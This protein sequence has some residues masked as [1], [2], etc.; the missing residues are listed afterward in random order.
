LTIAIFKGR[1]MAGHEKQAT[2]AAR[3][4]KHRAN[5][6]LKSEIAELE[7]QLD[8]TPGNRKFK[9]PVYKRLVTLWNQLQPEA[10]AS[11]EKFGANVISSAD[12]TISQDWC[13]GSTDDGEEHVLAEAHGRSSGVISGT[14]RNSQK[15][16][17]PNWLLDAKLVA[18]FQQ[19]LKAEKSAKRGTDDEYAAD[20][21]NQDLRLLRSYFVEGFSLEEIYL[22]NAQLPEKCDPASEKGSKAL[23]R[24]IKKL[25][26]SGY[27]LL[28][29]ST[30]TESEKEAARLDRED[31]EQRII[32]RSQYGK[33]ADPDRFL[34]KGNSTRSQESE[35]Q[36]ELKRIADEDNRRAKAAA[37]ASTISKPKAKRRPQP[38]PQPAAQPEP[39]TL[40]VD[41]PAPRPLWVPPTGVSH[42]LIRLG[43]LANLAK[44]MSPPSAVAG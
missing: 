11:T 18:T 28:E 33:G 9:S 10:Q 2:S 35:L 34:K 14:P 20:L 30:P 43:I 17:C 12:K 29:I 37:K 24:Y 19:L 13:F 7:L 40:R 6:K 26:D 22:W 16:N 5:E 15:F 23:Q 4:A 36:R 25:V 27:R 32:E 3:V 44:A 39:I 42:E 31:Q 8:A 1:K 38:A 41:R 21:V